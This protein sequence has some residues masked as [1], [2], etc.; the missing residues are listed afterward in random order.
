M[1]KWLEYYF[2]HTAVVPADDP[3]LADII[4][5]NKKSQLFN[6]RV[7]PFGVS[8]EMS[9]LFAWMWIN[10]YV[11]NI[12]DGRVV[13]SKVESRETDKN[14]ASVEFIP[15]QAAAFAI[16]LNGNKEIVPLPQLEQWAFVPPQDAI[17]Q[18]EQAALSPDLLSAVPW[19][20]RNMV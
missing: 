4:E 1:R 16:G 3:R 19:S 14:G 7:L 15:V 9:S 13:V 18:I 20:L 8:M 6:L 17:R 10:Q 11:Y 2:D 5:T 12:T